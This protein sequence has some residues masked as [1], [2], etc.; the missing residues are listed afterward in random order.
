MHTWRSPRRVISKPRRSEV[1]PAGPHSSG[2]H[3]SACI[4]LLRLLNRRTRAALSSADQLREEG[5]SSS[6]LQG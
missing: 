5:G 3:P 4:S 2:R 1:P 6:R